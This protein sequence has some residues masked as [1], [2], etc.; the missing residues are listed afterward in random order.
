M[1]LVAASKKLIKFDP[2]TFL[3]TITVV[4]RS[5]P[6]PKSRRSL[7]RATRLMLFFI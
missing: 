3:S 5:K 4:G 6:L 1:P 7:L 2:T